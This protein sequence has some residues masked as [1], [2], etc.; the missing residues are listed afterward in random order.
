MRNRGLS[1]LA[2]GKAEPGRQ[3]QT[4][5]EK[6]PGRKGVGEVGSAGSREGGL[7]LVYLTPL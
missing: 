7:L 5:D 1:P 4:L 2:D 3:F 6:G